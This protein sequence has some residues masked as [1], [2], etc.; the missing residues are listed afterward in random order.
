MPARLWRFSRQGRPTATW[1]RDGMDLV[2]IM[3]TAGKAR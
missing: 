2:S 1:G 3:P